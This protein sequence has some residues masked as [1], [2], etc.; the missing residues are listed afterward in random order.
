MLFECFCCFDPLLKNF[1]LFD[2]NL[3]SKL[4]GLVVYKHNFPLIIPNIL[5]CAF[6]FT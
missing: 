1:M 2:P 4:F 3:H 6:M 5:H